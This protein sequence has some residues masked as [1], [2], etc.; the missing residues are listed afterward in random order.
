METTN[1]IM[2]V[3]SGF[4]ST[5]QVAHW[6]VKLFDNVA[7]NKLSLIKPKPVQTSKR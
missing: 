7:Q 4:R 1:M 2:L 3:A 6:P 5:F